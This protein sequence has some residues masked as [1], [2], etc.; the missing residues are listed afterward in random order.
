MTVRKHMHMQP[1]DGY[2][3]RTYVKG[4]SVSSN[5]ATVLHVHCYCI[6]HTPYSCYQHNRLGAV[7]IQACGFKKMRCGMNVICIDAHAC[8]KADTCT[9]REPQR[10]TAHRAHHNT[11]LSGMQPLAHTSLLLTHTKCVADAL[12]CML[13]ELS[14]CLHHTERQ[15]LLHWICHVVHSVLYK[16][17]QSS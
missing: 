1:P 4:S 10:L 12:H 14:W 6:V 2:M 5:A 11:C 16:P 17:H 3:L 7:C 15:L 13:H 9:V 8:W